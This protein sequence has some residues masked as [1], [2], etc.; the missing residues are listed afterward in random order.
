MGFF[1]SNDLGQDLL[2]GDQISQYMGSCDEIF[3]QAV[4]NR[5]IGTGEDH[6]DIQS[7]L[8]PLLNRSPHE[9]FHQVEILPSQNSHTHLFGQGL[10]DSRH[11]SE[12]G[13]IFT[14]TF[15]YCNKDT[16]FSNWDYPDRQSE[17]TNMMMTSNED[18]A[19]IQNTLGVNQQDISK[20]AGK[21]TDESQY[22]RY[23]N[24]IFEG[25]Q[26]V[27][28]HF[29]T[30]TSH[31]NR[32]IPFSDEIIS[33]EAE[34][35]K[36]TKGSPNKG[37]SRFSDSC[38]GS[39]SIE[40]Y[41]I[42]D[43]EIQGFAFQQGGEFDSAGTHLE[44]INSNMNKEINNPKH[45]YA[46]E[47]LSPEL[48]LLNPPTELQY[49]SYSSILPEVMSPRRLDC[50]RL[51]ERKNCL[52][53]YNSLLEQDVTSSFPANQGQ[54]TASQIPAH[55]TLGLP[56]TSHLI[57]TPN[58]KDPGASNSG[59]EQITNPENEIPG[60]VQEDLLI[61]NPSNIWG[62]HINNVMGWQFLPNIHH[63][64]GTSNTP[65][66]KGDD[67]EHSSLDLHSSNNQG[68]TSAWF[69]QSFEPSLLDMEESGK[70]FDKSWKNGNGKR[71]PFCLTTQNIPETYQ[72]H[73]MQK[74][75]MTEMDF[76]LIDSFI[77]KQRQGY[78]SGEGSVTEH[79]TTSM[80]DPPHC[81]N[82][83][84][85]Y[86][87][88]EVNGICTRHSLPTASNPATH[89]SSTSRLDKIY[90]LDSKNNSKEMFVSSGNVIMGGCILEENDGKLTKKNSRKEPNTDIYR[91]QI[92]SEFDTKAEEPVEP[93]MI[94][95]D[96]FLEA[97][98]KPRGWTSRNEQIL[99]RRFKLLTHEF[100]LMLAKAQLNYVCNRDEVDSTLVEG[101]NWLID[102]WRTI[103]VETVKFKDFPQVIECNKAFYPNTIEYTMSLR[104]LKDDIFDF[105][106]QRFSACWK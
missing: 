57:A 62:D 24:N 80:Q 91:K 104:L 43:F 39:L 27:S 56:V 88:I 60:L 48:P 73:S 84:E 34:T 22:G 95:L 33:H 17:Q 74:K 25:F 4:E 75:L 12:Q 87:T 93:F 94:K 47:K 103:P 89:P 40:D 31:S 66:S 97:E 20:L 13:G 30:P 14:D 98:M 8:W 16:R 99:T 83:H 36:G 68:S 55:T 101:Y 44:G 77:S 1:S 71:L 37:E 58:F 90:P 79:V 100:M 45:S 61:D 19:C 26:T 51:F 29:L 46:P 81:C 96:H 28:P 3:G 102:I 50:S 63:S 6:N 5:H 54:H 41:P 70:F 32:C 2:N 64:S 72:E 10:E 76:N 86:D 35:S 11:I 21:T 65:S 78:H 23:P 42:S 82:H 53:A 85:D 9:Y 7:D 106:Q 38:A 59:K 67:Y 15:R 92:R 69:T 49:S 105:N 18:G 52:N